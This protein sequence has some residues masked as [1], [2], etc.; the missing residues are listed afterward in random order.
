MTAFAAPENHAATV[1]TTA[2]PI[3]TGLPVLLPAVAGPK[4]GLTPARERRRLKPVILKFVQ[5]LLLGGV[6]GVPGAPVPLVAVVVAKVGLI[7]AMAKPNLDPVTLSP[8][9]TP[10]VLPLVVPLSVAKAM[11][12]AVTAQIRIMEHPPL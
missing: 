12:V 10:V 2:P 1:L 8:V 5:L 9:A 4:P 6:V 3:A 7:P 11:A